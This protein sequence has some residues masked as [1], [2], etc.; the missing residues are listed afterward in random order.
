M[1]A[2]VPQQEECPFIRTE[3][4]STIAEEAMEPFLDKIQQMIDTI[5]KMAPQAK[6]AITLLDDTYLSVINAT[7]NATIRCFVCAKCN[8]CRRDT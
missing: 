8:S 3:A 1:N 4:L 5:T 2:P 7:Q 6:S